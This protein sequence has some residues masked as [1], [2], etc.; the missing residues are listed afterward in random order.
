LVDKPGANTA[1]KEEQ[2]VS[3]IT[4]SITIRNVTVKNTFFIIP[5]LNMI[6]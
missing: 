3:P 5:P 4:A 6:L 1:G 2:L